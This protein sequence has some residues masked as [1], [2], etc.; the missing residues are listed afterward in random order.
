MKAIETTFDQPGKLLCTWKQRTQYLFE[1]EYFMC[2]ETQNKSLSDVK[3]KY[4]CVFVSKA[5]MMPVTANVEATIA[6]Q[7]QEV[8]VQVVSSMCK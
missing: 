6:N 8:I 2:D 3:C 1:K 7:S 5:K 4:V